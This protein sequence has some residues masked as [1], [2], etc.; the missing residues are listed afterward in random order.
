MDTRSCRSRISAAK[1]IVLTGD[2]ATMKGQRPKLSFGGLCLLIEMI[3]GIVAHILTTLLWSLILST[4]MPSH[5]KHG[6]ML[7]DGVMFRG[8][9]MDQGILCGVA[10]G[11]L[12]RG[13]QEHRT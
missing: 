9:T 2:G 11:M 3:S 4:A 5:R 13:M 1:G 8:S 6:P 7:D 12:F 10:S